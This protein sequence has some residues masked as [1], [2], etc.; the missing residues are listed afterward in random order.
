MKKKTI[1]VPE[2]DLINWDPDK[3]RFYLKYPYLFFDI[4]KACIDHPE[5]NVNLN[6]EEKKAY[7]YFEASFNGKH[8]KEK[9]D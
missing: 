8:R 3:I 5:F 9:T 4:V 6:E 1:D 2:Q 7:Y